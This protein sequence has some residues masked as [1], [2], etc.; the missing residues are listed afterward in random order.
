[1]ASLFVLP[2]CLAALFGAY[3][4]VVAADTVALPEVASLTLVGPANLGY[5]A[6][7]VRSGKPITV[8][9]LG[10]SITVGS[11]A[12]EFGRNYYWLSRTAIETA[13]A[14]HGGGKLTTIT[15]AIGGTNSSYGAHPAGAQT[16][17]QKPALLVVEYAVNDCPGT[18]G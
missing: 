9:Y 8:A 4:T 10:G 17:N 18:H 16:L 1:M 15:G 12:S 7:Q 5:F 6:G 3:S 2:C 11:G 14:K 13:I